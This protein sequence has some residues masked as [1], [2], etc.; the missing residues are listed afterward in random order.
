MFFS[1]PVQMYH[2]ALLF[3]LFSLPTS[4]KN[5]GENLLS[6][7]GRRGA[8]SRQELSNEYLVAKFGLGF[9]SFLKRPERSCLLACFDTAGTSPCRERVVCQEVVKQLLK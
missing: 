2:T 6:F 9:F 4:T 7:C 3:S 8:R 5:R 1:Y